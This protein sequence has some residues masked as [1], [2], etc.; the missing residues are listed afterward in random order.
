MFTVKEI[1][2]FEIADEMAL[3]ADGENAQMGAYS[4]RWREIPADA[5][6]RQPLHP[7]GAQAAPAGNIASGR[8]RR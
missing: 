5:F 2:V 6:S 7:G 8:G 3:P 1:E 4:K